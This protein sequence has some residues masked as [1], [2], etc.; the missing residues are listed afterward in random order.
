MFPLPFW[1]QGGNDWLRLPVRSSFS[2]RSVASLQ[3]QPAYRAMVACSI[4]GFACE[5][6]VTRVARRRSQYAARE[7]K[8][9]RTLLKVLP[10]CR[11]FD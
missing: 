11:S 5:I 9:L 4:V 10:A 3:H 6:A 2:V 8:M 1:C 7:A